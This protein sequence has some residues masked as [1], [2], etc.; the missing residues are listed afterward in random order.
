MSVIHYRAIGRVRGKLYTVIF[1]QREDGQGE[2][3]HLVT[4][5][6]STKQERKAYEEHT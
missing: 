6:K 2:Y 3:Y 4:L 1:E 5:W